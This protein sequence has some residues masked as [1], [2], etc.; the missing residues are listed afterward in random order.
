MQL[1]HVSPCYETIASRQLVGMAMTC[2]T[3]ILVTWLTV[4]AKR[5]DREENGR[6]KE[7]TDEP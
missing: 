5:K 4:R 7:R 2:I 3:T 1:D 6:R